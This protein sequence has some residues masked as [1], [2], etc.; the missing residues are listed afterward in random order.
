[1]LHA[2]GGALGWLSYAL[3]PSYRGRFD[4]NAAQAG[5]P[6]E[7]S[8]AAVA[9]AGRLILELPYLWMRPAGAPLEPPVVWTGAEHIDAAHRAGRGLVFLTPHMGC[10][11]VTAQAYAERCGRDHP[12]TVLYRPAR[13]RWLREL[14]GTAR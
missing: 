8:R 6:R 10:F 5:V 14:V 9:E 1:I 12:M 7:A 11:E 4:A 3:S 13:K 2:V